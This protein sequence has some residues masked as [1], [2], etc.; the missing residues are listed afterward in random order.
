MPDPGR[1]RGPRVRVLGPEQ[2]FQTPPIPREHAAQGEWVGVAHGLEQPRFGL[3]VGVVGRQHGVGAVGMSKRLNHACPPCGPRLE[4]LAPCFS[5]SASKWSSSNGHPN[6]SASSA[7]NTASCSLPPGMVVHMGDHGGTPSDS[8]DVQKHRR[9]EAPTGPHHHGLPLVHRSHQGVVHVLLE[10]GHR[11]RQDLRAA[12]LS[13][14]SLYSSSPWANRVSAPPTV[15]STGRVRPVHQAADDHVEV[16]V[17]LG[18][19]VA[20][21]AAVH[22]RPC[23]RG[24]Q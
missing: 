22:P 8:R 10:G 18:V 1:W 11:S 13:K 3:V 9:I 19:H 4:T 17:A 5:S 23:P 2:R 21:G 12:T 6:R 20:N 16:P 24:R 14:H 7:T 15:A